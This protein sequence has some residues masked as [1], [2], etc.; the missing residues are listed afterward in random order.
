MR[1]ITR[2]Q[3]IEAGLKRYFTGQPCGKGHVSARFIGTYGCVTCAVERARAK[4]VSLGARPRPRT[5]EER[6]LGRLE[7]LRR[8]RESHPDRVRESQRKFKAAKP[9]RM[10]EIKRK[11]NAENPDAVRLKHHRRRARKIG[12]VSRDVI[13]RLTALQRGRCAN[14]R[15]SGIRLEVDHVMPLASGGLHADENLQLLCGGCNRAKSAK[16]PI[17]WAQ[18]QGRLL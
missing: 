11:W 3:A 12:R 1:L 10:R 5:D 14:C 4:R 13:Q 9:L 7:S 17:R 2:E 18:E 16:D 15:A 8:Y 6:R